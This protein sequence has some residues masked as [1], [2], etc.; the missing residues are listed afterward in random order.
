MNSETV[1]AWVPA[2][3]HRLQ[4]SKYS[5]LEDMEALHITSDRG[6]TRYRP[7]YQSIR[8]VVVPIKCLGFYR[9]LQV[10]TRFNKTLKCKTCSRYSI[11]TLVDKVVMKVQVHVKLNMLIST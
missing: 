5:G 3:S 9:V 1:K 8:E 10:F 4:Y 11:L 6:G 2:V 7:I